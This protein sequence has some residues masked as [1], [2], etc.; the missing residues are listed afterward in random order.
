M[1]E[2]MMMFGFLWSGILAVVVVGYVGF[3]VLDRIQRWKQARRDQRIEARTM[4]TIADLERQRPWTIVIDPPYGIPEHS[5]E[6]TLKEIH[7]RFVPGDTD[8]EIIAR[9]TGD[10]Q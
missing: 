6:I 5:P 1:K 7:Y 4:A 3:R 2:T 8:Q 9:L 10:T